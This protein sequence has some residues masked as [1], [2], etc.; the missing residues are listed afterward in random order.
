M[1]KQIFLDKNMAALAIRYPQ[2]ALKLKDVTPSGNY[3]LTNTPSGY[4][5]LLVKHNDSF[6]SFYDPDDPVGSAER[7]VEAQLMKFAPVVVFLG[8]GLGYHL[9]YFL[10]NQSNKLDTRKIIIYEKDIEILKFTL[11]SGDFTNIINHPNI[12]FFVDDDMDTSHIPLRTTILLDEVYDLRSIKIVPLPTSIKIHHE[13]YTK[14]VETV[15]KSA[16]QLMIIIGN[17]PMDALVGVENMMLNL[18]HMFSNPGIIE[19]KDKFKGRPGILVAAG[20][21]LN[22]NMH[23]LKDIRDK[24]LIFACDTS[25]IP[26][27][28]NGIKPHFT[29]SLERVP[30]T[31]LY[32]SG[33][34]DLSDV[35]YLAMAV[36][37][38]DTIES[39]KGRKFAAYRHYPHYEWLEND[40]GQI[41]C[42]VSIANLVF[43]VLA[44][45]GCDP[46]ILVGQDLAYANTGETHVK[47]NV[48]GEHAPNLLA[49]PIIELEGNDGN[50]VKSERNWEIMKI[51][52]E[53]NV[54]AYPGTCIN[55]TEGGAK[56][57]GTK[58]MTLQDAIDQFCTVPFY[59][60]KVFDDVYDK[61][62]GGVNVQAEMERINKKCKY[63]NELL[64]TIIE[65]FDEA[66]KES[67]K[68]DKDIIRQFINGSDIS[69]EDVDKLL[70]IEKKWLEMS[71]RIYSR[72]DVYEINIQTI[73]PY[74]VWLASELSFLK[75][76][77]KDKKI[78]SMARV[79]KMSEW[80]SV[81][82]SLLVF[83]RNILT[84][85]EKTTALEAGL[86]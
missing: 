54:S 51:I 7:Y 70:S 47:G 22:K 78:L 9:D 44:Y 80:L 16:R 40:K 23:L 19:C 59:P 58:V 32:Y 75:D 14:A 38:P 1:N 50:P 30:G 73:Q 68:I 85:T 12:Y 49:A 84:R 18:R 4:S 10:R 11:S 31:E 61:F 43:S 67:K 52:Y 28:K 41:G 17:D 65:E 76:I 20:P 79:K 36:L 57:R 64:E 39:F 69:D 71:Q 66:I 81:V 13:Y 3:K 56:I 42:G 72:K 29:S 55:A 83:T 77:Y 5:N 45:L 26:L 53:E 25:L 6:L 62:Q 21:S 82:G 15:K 86:C 48:Y 74:D 27:M 33:L 8:I 2:I 37:M 24:A 34:N 46:I 60:Q 63:T 35:Y